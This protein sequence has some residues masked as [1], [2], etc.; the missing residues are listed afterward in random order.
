MV[1]SPRPLPNFRYTLANFELER[2]ISSSKSGGQLIN[3]VEYA[4]PAWKFTATTAYLNYSD[5]QKANAWYDSLCG[6]LQSALIRSPHYCCPRAHIHNRGAEKQSGV[7]TDIK[8]RNILTVDSVRAEL[9]LSAGDFVSLQ[10]QAYYA[11]ARVVEAYGNG[12]IRTIEIQPKLPGYIEKGAE[13]KFDRAELLMRPDVSN[14]SKWSRDRPT[15]SI[16]FLE[17][18]L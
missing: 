8:N 5:G 4:D 7:L 11:L 16:T 15:L 1:T 2:F 18:R 13:V 3:I 6:G 14:V 17:S 10:Y 12:N 9:L